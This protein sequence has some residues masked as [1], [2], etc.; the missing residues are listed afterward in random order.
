[1]Q[2]S[3]DSAHSILSSYAISS[4]TARELQLYRRRRRYHQPETDSNRELSIKHTSSI[5]AS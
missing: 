3:I 5:L 1:M 2:P 4:L